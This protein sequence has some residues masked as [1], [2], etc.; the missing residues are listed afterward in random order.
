MPKVIGIRGKAITQLLVALQNLGCSYYVIDQDGAD[1]I[2]GDPLKK[3]KSRK[4]RKYP[5]GTLQGYY[6]PLIKD[7]EPGNTAEIPAGRFT[8]KDLQAGVASKASAMWG[9]GTYITSRNPDKNV[10]EVLRIT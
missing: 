3:E 7:L 10:L 4:P 8:L 1:Y 6:L 9:N 2:H 5:Y